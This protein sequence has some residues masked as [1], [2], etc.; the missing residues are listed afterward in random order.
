M[1]FCKMK[2]Q[3]IAEKNISYNSRKVKST[4]DIVQ[5][6]NSFEELDK[7]AEEITLQICLNNKNQIIAYTE[8]AKGRI[9]SC[10]VDMK[11]IFKTVLICNASKFIIVHNHPSGD[12]EV[13]EKDIEVTEHIKNAAT[14]M[15]IDFVDHIIIA[16]NK[17]KSCMFEKKVKELKKEW[18]E[19]KF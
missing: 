11:T 3:Q 19:K 8:I 10:N 13:S 5:F 6:I 1:K 16:D 14:I 9:N 4:L 18:M 7:L 15:N 12:V 2:L 17:Y